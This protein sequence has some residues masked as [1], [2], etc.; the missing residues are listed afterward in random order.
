MNNRYFNIKTQLKEN[1]NLKFLL[2]E[3][4]VRLSWISFINLFFFPFRYIFYGRVHL[5]TRISCDANFRNLKNIYLSNKV[6]VNKG[7][8]LWAGLEHG[9]RIGAHTQLN[10][11]TIIYGNVSIGNFAMVASHVMLAGGGHETNNTII[12]MKFQSSTS[13]VG[14]SIEDDVWI[15]ANS[16]IL[17][18]VT[19]KKGA[20]IGAGSVVTSNVGEYD[21]FAE[22]LAVKIKHRIV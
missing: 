11:Y 20:I 12:P 5:S 18:G 1:L 17:D 9:T 6:E 21:V 14:I 15:R 16:V 2:F 19:I 8:I 13:K 3:K 4:A 22:V 7:V 10:P